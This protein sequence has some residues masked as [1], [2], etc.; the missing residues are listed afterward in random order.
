MLS[1]VSGAMSEGGALETADDSL[2]GGDGDEVGVSAVG[3][4]AE[5]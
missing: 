2:E 4:D 5:L 3:S 1:I